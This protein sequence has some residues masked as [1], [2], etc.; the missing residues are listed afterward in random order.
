MRFK[1]IQPR[2]KKITDEELIADVNKLATE[3]GKRTVSIA[4]YEKMGKFSFCTFYRRFRNWYKVLE[5]AGLE[6]TLPPA[7]CTDEDLMKNIESMWRRLGRQPRYAEAG[8]PFSKYSQSRYE[9]R[10]GSWMKAL[11]AFEAYAKENNLQA[12]ETI[13]DEYEEYFNLSPRK[14]GLKRE[15]LTQYARQG[16]AVAGTD[17]PAK[18]GD[19]KPIEHKTGRVPSTRMRMDVMMRDNFRCKRCGRSPATTPGLELQIDHALAWA[20]GGETVMDNL[21]TLCSECNFGKAAR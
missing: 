1:V 2:N 10:Y 16:I 11:E 9:R 17:P 7:E 15:I 4:E 6:Y 3:L 14:R 18:P 13:L 8:K 12:H 5:R 21:E 19:D 20:K